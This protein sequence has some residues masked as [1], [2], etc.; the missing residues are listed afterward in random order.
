MGEGTANNV[1]VFFFKGNGYECMNYV[2]SCLVLTPIKTF[3]A[4]FQEI[5]KCPLDLGSPSP[6][7]QS[8]IMS[9]FFLHHDFFFSY[10]VIV[11]F[12]PTM[13]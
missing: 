1:W 3:I 2:Q 8:Y 11:V 12:Q 13:C 7:W 5:W 6:T 9:D 10:R 4:L